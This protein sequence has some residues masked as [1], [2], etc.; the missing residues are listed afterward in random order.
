[1]PPSLSEVRAFDWTVDELR[2]AL[3]RPKP[4]E[5]AHLRMAPRPRS[6]REDFPCTDPPRQSAVLLLLYPGDE[7][8]GLVLTRRAD[9]LT[10]HR[11]QIS[12]PGGAWEPQDPGLAHTA[13][14]E[15]EE[16][17]G[18]ALSEAEVLGALTSL[19][20][21]PSNYVIHPYVALVPRRPPFAPCYAEVAELLEVPLSLL[22][23]KELQRTETWS[24]RQREVEVPFFHLYG[25][26]VWGATAMILSEFAAI[27][28]EHM[29]LQGAVNG[30]WSPT[31]GE[32]TG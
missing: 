9:T 3:A 25:H 30:A 10:H 12:L 5:K 7:G 15:T 20:T 2:A 6:R 13:L 8:L 16:E 4:G 32:Q 31:W 27:L 24:I 23:N 22:L 29:T 14:R 1:M 17:L 28:E 11:G 19:Y 26:K 21:A 18:V